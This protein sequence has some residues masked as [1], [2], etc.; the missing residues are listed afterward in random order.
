[1]PQ[2]QN[3]PSRA[4]EENPLATIVVASE[5]RTQW[6]SGCPTPNVD[7]GTGDKCMF[8]LHACLHQSGIQRDFSIRLKFILRKL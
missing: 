2:E 8:V 6:E 5:K 7:S 4:K 3:A 1:M